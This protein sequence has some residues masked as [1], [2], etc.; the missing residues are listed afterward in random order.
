MTKRQTVENPLYKGERIPQFPKNKVKH[1]CKSMAAIEA[2]IARAKA[3]SHFYTPEWERLEGLREIERIKNNKF[4]AR[5]EKQLNNLQNPY[6]EPT[7]E[8]CKTWTGTKEEWLAA[9]RA[10]N[11]AAARNNLNKKMPREMELLEALSDES[12]RTSLEVRNIP[13]TPQNVIQEKSRIFDELEQLKE[14]SKGTDLFQDAALESLSAEGILHNLALKG[15]ETTPENI[16]AES[17]LIIEGLESGKVSAFGMS[18]AREAKKKADHIAWIE[19]S[20]NDNDAI[21]RAALFPHEVIKNN[22]AWRSRAS[23]LKL[24][25]LENDKCT[26]EQV[27]QEMYFPT[28]S[29]PEAYTTQRAALCDLGDI[30]RKWLVAYKNKSLPAPTDKKERARRASKAYRR[31]EKV[32]LL[33]TKKTVIFPVS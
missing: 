32:K 10:I 14:Q 23:V 5:L 16:K 18:R 1:H 2:D 11:K 7:N 17:A 33:K 31:R 27:E 19:S 6:W 15:L 13:C 26:P 20:A 8:P 21:L 30:D 28:L 25:V 3:L 12:I 22:G 24:G 9:R 29:D 4:I